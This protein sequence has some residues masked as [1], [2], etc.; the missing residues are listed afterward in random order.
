MVFG[1]GKKKP[2]RKPAPRTFDEEYDDEFGYELD[3]DS[4]ALGD[5]EGEIDLTDAPSAPRRRP[6]PPRDEPRRR[7]G[8]SPPPPAEP[9]LGARDAEEATFVPGRRED[10]PVD[11]GPA[12]VDPDEE[13]D[14]YP[15]QTCYIEPPAETVV[16]VVGWLVATTGAAR[17]RDH[18]LASR[19]RIG[20]RQDS[21]VHLDD[22]FVSSRHAEILVE[23]EEFVLRDLGST[24]G[25]FCGGERI[26]ESRLRDG[27]R[28]R[29]GQ[30][31]FVFACVR[32]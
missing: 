25:T 30:S 16:R 19:T 5:S 22:T 31:E 9:D 32:L 17:G 3:S 4:E 6:S 15:D 27:D 10:V 14:E 26:S 1:W 7:R 28:L 24:N 29:F 13:L 21:D 11:E 23:G 18:R 2:G 12:R 20:T 8:A